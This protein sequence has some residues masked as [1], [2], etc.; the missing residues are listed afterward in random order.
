VSE[1]QKPGQEQ[2]A[3]TLRR[4]WELALHLLATKVSKVTFEGYI[5]PIQPLQYEGS[6]I[7]LGVANPFAREWL[8]KKYA[9]PIR[10]ALEF[11]LDT[12]GL[13]IRFVVLARDAQPPLE[14][15]GAARKSGSPADALQPALPLDEEETAPEAPLAATGSLFAAP[16]PAPPPPVTVRAPG[17]RGAAKKTPPRRP[18]GDQP[19]IPCLPLNAR[20]V[21]ESFLIGRS[22]RLAHA[23]AL[24]VA[25]QPGEVYNPLFLYGGPGLGKTHLLQA[26]AQALQRTRPELRVAYISG[27]YFAQHYIGALREHNTEAFR[28]QYREV[29]VWLVDDVQFIAGKEHTKEEFFHTFNTL[30]QTGKQ[31]VLASDRS[32]R[33]LNTMDERLRS[34]FQ[35]G[36]I[37]DIGA[38]DLETRIAI[39]QQVRSREDIAVA[40]DVLEYIASAIQ[41]NIRALEG[42]L[43]KLIA[44]SSIMNAPVSAALAQGVLNEYFIEKPV[45]IKRVTVDDVVGAVAERFGTTVRE[46]KG[47]S[48]HKDVSLA[49]HVAMYLC[50]ELLPGEN[51]RIVGNAFG[52]RDH[53]TI[54]KACQK[55]RALMDFDPELEEMVRQLT[56]ELAS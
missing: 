6:V 11:H 48:R 34:R 46:I 36:L 24:A 27:E 40:D 4:A 18:N 23:G 14:T 33:E 21:F 3:S 22:N 38:P 28:R 55:L 47:P 7:T 44:Y 30:Y 51:I 37:A 32:P 5:R 42:A 50:R 53:T 25:A 49:R 41:S 1:E 52:G 16:E 35:S 31:I 56:K 13:Q 10:S 19:P 8:E 54:I 43:T 20:F 9:N 45:R 39:L 29:D 2:D 26:I 12:T 17:G 15:G